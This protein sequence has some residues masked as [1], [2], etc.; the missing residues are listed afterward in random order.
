MHNVLVYGLHLLNVGNVAFSSKTFVLVN[1]KDF[2]KCVCSTYLIKQNAEVSHVHHI[3]NE[4]CILGKSC[5]LESTQEL[6]ICG[7]PMRAV[8]QEDFFQF[9]SLNET[10]LL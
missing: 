2:L 9:V 3:G 10:G 1:T 6:N 4:L 7:S 8:S 5:K